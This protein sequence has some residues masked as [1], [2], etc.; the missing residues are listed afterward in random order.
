MLVF[1]SILTEWDRGE[2]PTYLTSFNKINMNLLPEL[3]NTG[4]IV[5]E[6]RSH[7]EEIKRLKKTLKQQN[8]KQRKPR[9]EK[10]SFKSKK[11]IGIGNTCHKCGEI[12]TRKAHVTP[13]LKFHYT[14]W[15][16]CKCGVVRHYDEF[17]SEAWKE[18]ERQGN[19]INSL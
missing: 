4:K 13:P 1:Y 5:E 14:Q 11:V 3:D 10:K 12:M 17:K 18:Y 19:F 15:D 6:I 7:Q 2:V 8:K 16:V 9:E